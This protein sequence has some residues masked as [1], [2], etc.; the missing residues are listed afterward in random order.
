[1]IFLGNTLTS[2]QHLLLHLLFILLTVNGAFTKVQITHMHR[3]APITS[4]KLTRG[5]LMTGWTDPEDDFHVLYKNLK[6]LLPR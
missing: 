5:P 2:W 3:F 1:M 6:F 4:W